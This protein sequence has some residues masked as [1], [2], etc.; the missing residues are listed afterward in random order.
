M[1]KQDILTSLCLSNGLSKDC[2][3]KKHKHNLY[4]QVVT[5]K[6]LFTPYHQPCI[7]GIQNHL[8]QRLQDNSLPSKT[9]GC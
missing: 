9:L 2:P 5:V 3:E 4:T 7:R 6:F 8:P 1:I